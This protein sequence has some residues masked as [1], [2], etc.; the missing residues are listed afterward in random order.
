MEVTLKKFMETVFLCISKK[1]LDYKKFAEHIISYGGIE[2]ENVSPID[3]FNLFEENFSNNREELLYAF[4]EV[5]YSYKFADSADE[6]CYG[7]FSLIVLCRLSSKNKD[8]FYTDFDKMIE[9]Y[10]FFHTKIDDELSIALF[11]LCFVETPRYDEIIYYLLAHP[12]KYFPKWLK[13]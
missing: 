3:I 2:M 8:D 5:M 10:Y 7:I 11:H 4:S 9:M 1:E 12:D 6:L 13:S